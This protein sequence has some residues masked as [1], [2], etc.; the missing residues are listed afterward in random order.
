M[1]WTK[2]K[3]VISASLMAGSLIGLVEALS[4][5]VGASAG[6]Y[7]ALLWGVIGYSVVCLCMAPLSFSIALLLP[8]EEISLWLSLFFGKK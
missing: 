7:D 5:L 8:L 1:I 6:E 3:T 2:L 4:I